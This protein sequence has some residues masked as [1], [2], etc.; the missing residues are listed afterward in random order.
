MTLADDFIS[1]DGSEL[2]AD[3][4]TAFGITFTPTVSGIVLAV[5]GLVGAGYIFMNMVKPALESYE[6]V[7]SQQQEKQGQIDRLKSGDLQQQ[8]TNLNAELQAE[9]D[10]KS[11]ILTLFTNEKDLDTLLLDLSSFIAANQGKLINYT[12][13]SSVVTIQDGSLGTEV[14]GKLKKISIALEI[15]GTFSQ[16]QAILR[17]LERLQPLLVVQSYSSKVSQPPTAV[18]SVST[19][20]LVPSKEAKLQTQLKLDAIL[21]LSPQ[22]QEQAEQQNEEEKSES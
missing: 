2:A 11:R 10:L 14:N 6:Q 19:G 15:E 3:Y 22:E 20:E 7:K 16:I 12:P 5:V 17:D 9:Q 4:P 8:V 13:D 1:E 18:L 21:P